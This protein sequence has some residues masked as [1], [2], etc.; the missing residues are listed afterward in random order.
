MK[1]LTYREMTLG[2]G[3]SKPEHRERFDKRLTSGKGGHWVY[4]E[5][6]GIWFMAGF[7]AQR[8]AVLKAAR[9]ADDQANRV[10]PA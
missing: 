10:T 5:V 8:M 7:G 6:L 2:V 3:Q 9:A 1:S 4:L